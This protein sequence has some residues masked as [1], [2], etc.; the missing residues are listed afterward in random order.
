MAV[1]E[2]QVLAMANDTRYGLAASVWSRDVFKAMRAARTCRS[3][4]SMST[5]R[6]STS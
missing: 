6:S 2:E 3:T 1:A 4:R 5:P